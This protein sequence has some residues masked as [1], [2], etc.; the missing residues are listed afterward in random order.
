M[1][2]AGVTRVDLELGEVI[3]RLG[4]MVVGVLGHRLA[5]GLEVKL[6]VTVGEVAGL[7]VVGG[8]ERGGARKGETEKHGEEVHVV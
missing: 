2:L 6:H 7:V 3:A 1:E 5:A 8:G 4:P